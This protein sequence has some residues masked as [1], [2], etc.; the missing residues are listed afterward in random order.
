VA[1]Y[2]QRVDRLK[3][4][5]ALAVKQGID[6]T[7]AGF[8]DFILKAAAAQGLTPKTARGYVTTLLDAYRHDRWKAFLVYN[9]YVEKEEAEKWLSA[10]TR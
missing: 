10:H 7:H 5:V 9:P 4:I 2:Y 1:W 8:A 3:Q 6:S